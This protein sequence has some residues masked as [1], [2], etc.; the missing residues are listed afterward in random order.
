VEGLPAGDYLVA[1]AEDVDDRQWSTAAFS[2]AIA[3]RPHT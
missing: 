3:R 2:N 1:L